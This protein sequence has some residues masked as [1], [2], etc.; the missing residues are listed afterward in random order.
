MKSLHSVFFWSF[1][2]SQAKSIWEEYVVSQSWHQNA[3]NDFLFFLLKLHEKSKD[4]SDK[5][6]DVKIFDCSHCDTKFGLLF[7]D[8]NLWNLK[9]WR[10]KNM[11]SK[12]FIALIVIT[13]SAF[14]FVTGTSEICRHEDTKNMVSKLFIA[15]IVINIS[16]FF[17]RNFC[18]SQ[19]SKFSK[20]ES[21]G[22]P[23]GIG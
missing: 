8:R 17:D 2:K 11:V 6:Y 18:N 5:K 10:H 21:I 7:C 9:T 4:R 19:F 13:N 22:N 12:L 1:I 14:Y 20:V 15:L 16:A 3:T 23:A